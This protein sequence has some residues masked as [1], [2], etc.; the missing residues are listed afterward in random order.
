MATP[1][2]TVETQDAAPVPPSTA[3]AA[4]TPATAG[5]MVQEEPTDG[6]VLGGGGTSESAPPPLATPPPMVPTKTAVP[7]SAA[8][9]TESTIA[10]TASTTEAE[11]GSRVRGP[12]STTAAGGTSP[13]DNQATK[14]LTEE[15]SAPVLESAEP[16]VFDELGGSGRT[17]VWWRVLEAA[18][19]VLAVVF[20]AGWVFR[21]RANRRDLA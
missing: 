4:P 11:D 7:D 20:L 2:P 15:T 14:A 6:R 3:A 1:E 16:T 17:S 18:A 9:L 13:V 21:W 10:E 5:Q 8:I 19:G 12:T